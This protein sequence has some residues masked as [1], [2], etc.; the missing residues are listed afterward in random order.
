[1]VCKSGNAQFVSFCCVYWRQLGPTRTLSCTVCSSSWGGYGPIHAADVCHIV[2]QYPEDFRYVVSGGGGVFASSFMPLYAGLSQFT[3]SMDEH[4]GSPTC[5]MRP[6]YRPCGSGNSSIGARDH[7]SST[8][9]ETDTAEQQQGMG[10]QFVDLYA[11][12]RTL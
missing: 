3:L 6:G 7:T 12:Q 10:C 1:M 8:H 4:E 5:P 11:T 9:A 2:A